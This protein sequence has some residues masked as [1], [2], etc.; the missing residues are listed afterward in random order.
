MANDAKIVHVANENFLCALEFPKS[1]SMAL[2]WE[3]NACTHFC[4]EA[5]LRIEI[6]QNHR[7]LGNGHGSKV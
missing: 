5:L 6:P 7:Q 1:V 4:F 2:I 3:I